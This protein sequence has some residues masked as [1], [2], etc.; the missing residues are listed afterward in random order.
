MFFCS[1]CV[2]DFKN[3]GK[4][5]NPKSIIP[6]YG[7]CEG[8]GRTKQTVNVE[9]IDSTPIPMKHGGHQWVRMSYVPLNVMRVNRAG[10]IPYLQISIDQDQQRTADEQARHA[11][12]FCHVPLNDETF[13]TVCEPDTE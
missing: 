3:A 2:V 1:S 4:V 7:P 11:C 8:C 9:V 6:S 12:W 13:M 5:V 10:E